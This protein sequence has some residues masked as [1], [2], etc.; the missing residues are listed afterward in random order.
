MS[1]TLLAGLLAGLTAIIP[2]S[3]AAI[4]YVPPIV[5]HAGAGLVFR[6]RVNQMCEWIRP[7][8]SK[9]MCFYKDS[10]SWKTEQFQSSKL[11][12]LASNARNSSESVR[13]LERLLDALAQR[14][15]DWFY[16]PFRYLLIGT[17]LCMAVEQWRREHAESLRIWLHAWGEFEALNALAA[18][19]F[20]NPD[21][22]F[23]E[24]ADAP[25]ALKRERWA[26]R[27]YRTL[28][29]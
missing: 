16:A 18:Y 22:T 12:Q 17:Q 11:M 26:T 19:G 28:P 15:K 20:E 2:W 29:A 14:D 5:L 27:C 13:K 23:P 25:R 4:S 21:N 8:S 7:V 6:R 9:L 24:F 3:T 10:I 1:S